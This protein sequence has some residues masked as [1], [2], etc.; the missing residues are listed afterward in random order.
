MML[1]GCITD[2]LQLSA[3]HHYKVAGVDNNKAVKEYLETYLKTY[4]PKETTSVDA[5]EIRRHRDYQERYLKAQLVK[6][7][8][9]QGYYDAQ[10]S[11]QDD[12]VENSGVYTLNLGTG[13]TISNIT[14]TPEEFSDALTDIKIQKGQILVAADVLKSQ[15]TIYNKIQKNKCYYQIDISHQAVLDKNTKRAKIIYTINFQPEATFGSVE[16]QGNDKTKLS[17][18]NKVIPFKQGDCYRAEKVQSFREKLISTGLFSR[19]DINLPETLPQDGIVPIQV[20][21]KERA[22]RTVKAGAS[23]YTDDGLGFIVGWTHRNFFGGAEKLDAELKLSQRQQQL[24]VDVTKPF[25]IRKDQSLSLSASMERQDTEAFEELS[26][27][28]SASIRRSFT[29]RLSGSTGFSMELTRIRDK[30]TDVEDNFGLIS[31]PN[32]LTFDNRDN[33]LDPRKGWN[34]RAAV[35]P[36]V[37]AL[38]TTDPFFKSRLSASTYYG[39]TDDIVLAARASVGSIMGAD[40]ENVPATERFYSGGGGSVRG[41]GYQEVGDKINGSPTGGASVVEG[42]TEIRFKITDKIGAVTFIDAGNVSTEISP[43]FSDFSIGA[44]LGLRYYT[45]LG[46]IRFDLATPL[47]NKDETDQNYQ[48]YISIG[49]A[50]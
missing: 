16:F 44:G 11:Y 28:S 9:S 41:F 7:A 20:N 22:K 33:P 10:I 5:D 21:L 38:G 30:N 8:N 23:F 27:G 36:F 42:S 31:F 13:Y 46:P 39:F 19:A 49:Q 26:L 32:S 4:S 18:L 2:T 35:T 17:Y 45:A 34:I 29:R 37:D 50:F 6:A 3:P 15:Q 1:S 48:I 14:I 47:T 24:G 25:F 12:D 40:I 43:Q